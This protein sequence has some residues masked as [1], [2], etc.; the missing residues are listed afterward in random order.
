MSYMA[1]RKWF[2]I[3]LLHTPMSSYSKFSDLSLSLCAHTREH[4]CVQLLFCET[5]SCMTETEVCYIN[6]LT[7]LDKL[8]TD[9]SYTKDN[10]IG[11]I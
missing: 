3:A 2:Q 10:C 9:I 6:I 5:F 4:A 7:W 11:K 8:F 1:I